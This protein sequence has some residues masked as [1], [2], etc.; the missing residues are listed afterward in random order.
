MA[1][2]LSVFHIPGSP[3]SKT[4]RSMQVTIAGQVRSAQGSVGS[5]KAKF[6]DT[7]KY[8]GMMRSKETNAH[9]LGQAEERR[10]GA[11]LTRLGRILFPALGPFEKPHDWHQGSDDCSI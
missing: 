2:R 1:D 10:T 6:I 3:L 7:N 5:G 11:L 4:K 8:D 9:A